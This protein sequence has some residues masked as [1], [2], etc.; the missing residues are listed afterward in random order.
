MVATGTVPR[1]SAPREGGFRGGDRE[2]GYR[3]RR[4]RTGGFR[5]DERPRREGEF[6]RDDRAGG[7]ESFEGGRSSAPALPDDIVATDL[8]KDVRAELLSL[9]KPVAEP[10][11]PGT[12][13]RPAS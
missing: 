7:S 2:G 11:S 3:G 8:D 13:S 4:P 9:N 10:V 6:R 1:P 12:W 5:A